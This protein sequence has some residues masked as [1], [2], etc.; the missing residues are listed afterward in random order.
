[1]FAGHAKQANTNQEDVRV[2][3]TL[4]AAP[5]NIARAV[6][7]DRRTPSAQLVLC[8]EQDNML[9][10]RATDQITLSAHDAPRAVP[11]DNA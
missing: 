9:R 4:F 11:Q 6:A 7:Q 10:E 3:K 1:M 2:R 5:A 8:A